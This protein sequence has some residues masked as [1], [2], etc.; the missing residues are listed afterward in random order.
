MR[1]Y[2]ILSMAISDTVHPSRGDPNLTPVSP[3]DDA[4]TIQVNNVSWGGVLAGVVAGP[5][6]PSPGSSPGT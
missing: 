4:R 2:R 1:A 5:A 6:S 3:E